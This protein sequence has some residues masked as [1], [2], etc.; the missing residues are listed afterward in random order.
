MIIKCVAI[1]TVVQLG[2]ITKPVQ[3]LHGNNAFEKNYFKMPC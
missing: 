2:K 3:N 1:P